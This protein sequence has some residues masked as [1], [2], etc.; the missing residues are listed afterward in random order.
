MPSATDPNVWGLVC[1]L[2]EARNAARRR[3]YAA[4]ET[5][6]PAAGL[7]AVIETDLSA[8]LFHLSAISYR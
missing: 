3:R 1:V 4:D 5:G 7:Y 8:L 2:R 6:H